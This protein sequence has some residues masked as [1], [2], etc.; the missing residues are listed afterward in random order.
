ML[1]DERQC[2]TRGLQVVARQVTAE[3][4]RPQSGELFFSLCLSLPFPNP[5]PFFMLFSSCLNFVVLFSFREYNFVQFSHFLLIAV[6][7]PMLLCFLHVSPQNLC[8]SFSTSFQLFFHS[9][10]FVSMF[11]NF[12]IVQFRRFIILS[13]RELLLT[14]FFF[15]SLSR[16]Y[17]HDRNY[18]FTALIAHSTHTRL[19]SSLGAA[20]IYI[21]LISNVFMRKKIAHCEEA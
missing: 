6:L 2:R 8:L 10:L 21:F 12:R 1:A 11:I 19:S 13:A 5:P 20:F 15:P 18:L 9:V 14:L 7:D 3:Q 16:G 17:T 4:F